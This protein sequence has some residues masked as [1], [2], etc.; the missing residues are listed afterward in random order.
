MPTATI[1]LPVLPVWA[2]ALSSLLA[3]GVFLTYANTYW[4][5]IAGPLVRTCL[6]GAFFWT[7][8]ACL[9]GSHSEATALWWNR[10]F[11]PATPLFLVGIIESEM[12]VGGITVPRWY[13]WVW[14]GAVALVA[15]FADPRTMFFFHMHRVPDGYWLV[16]P[17]GWVLLSRGLLV[18][19]GVA[20]ALAILWH[21]FRRQGHGPRRWF[22]AAVALLALLMGF[23]DSVWAQGHR[24]IY[25][26]TWVAGLIVVAALWFELRREVRATYARL[27]TDQVSRASSRAFGELY[28]AASLEEGPVGAVFCDIDDFKVVNDRYG[29]AVGDDLLRAIV[30]GVQAV[31]GP[32][33][34]V[35]RLGGDELLVILPGAAAEAGAA[36]LARVAVAA[37]AATVAVGDGTIVPS[38]SLGWAWSDIRQGTFADLVE[39]AD[40]AMY[41]R[42]R[43]R[44]SALTR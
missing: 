21:I 1:P 29:H 35:V 7:V 41:E 23:N 33:D 10:L 32:R 38:V 37:Q 5:A 24:T 44:R 6:A 19:G 25:P 14:V 22:Y 15:F 43:S 42:K 27:D 9:Q 2:V 8:S 17:S 28:G 20:V 18:A 11:M 16:A 3:G 13:R 4:R 30:A 26:T 34:R 39:R 36:I 31:C 40:G 12:A